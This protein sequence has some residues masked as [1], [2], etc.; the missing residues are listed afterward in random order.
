MKYLVACLFLC[1]SLLVPAAENGRPN[2]LFA[3][4]DD[5]GRFASAYAASDGAGSAND[6]ISTPNFDRV[7]REGVL[8]KNAHVTAPSC[9]PC[10]SSLLSGQYFWRTGLGAILQGAVWDETIPS[11]P[12]LL[13][14]DGYHI[15]Q[16]YKVW[17]P[18]TPADAPFGGKQFAYERAG[19][20]FNGF[21]QRVTKMI[22]GGQTVE[23]AKQV[24]YAEV[25]KNFDDFLAA[26]EGDTPFCY[27]FG[28]TNVHRKWIKGSG[29]DLWGI[30]PDQLQGKMPGFLP[31]VPEV[32][33]DFADYFGEIHAFDHALGLLL[34]KLESSGELEN[35]LVVVSGD[36]GAPGFTHGKCNLYDAGTAVPLAVRWPGHGKA[37]RVVEDFVNLTDLAPTFLE[38]AGS[39]VPEVMTGKSLVNVLESENQGM[40][41]ATRSRVFTGRERHVAAVRPGGVGYPQRA[42]RTAEHLYII[43]FQPDRYP[44][45]DPYQIRG[46]SAPDHDKLENNTF[47]TYGDMDAGPTKAWLIEHRADPKWERF[48]DLAFAKRPRVELYQRRQDPH[49]MRNLADNEEFAAI[50]AEL[51]AE[52]MRELRRTGDP[53]V[54]GDGLT[55]EKPPYVGPWKKRR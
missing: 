8:F 9:T 12:L 40:V 42:I 23:A 45:G 3:F 18:G 1:Q 41:D 11:F 5:W 14:G 19:Q 21:S 34:R 30:D 26:R 51:H 47:A 53:R 24:M 22:A 36:H 4:A 32:R 49:Q 2:I 6:V 35:T 7:A 44:M 52:L 54:T 33:Q 27:W 10:R 29:K 16:T 13:R 25:E 17:S 50:K 37:G 39:A 43:N 48:Y 28:P 15:G 46:D 55:F 20:K 31:D 38:A